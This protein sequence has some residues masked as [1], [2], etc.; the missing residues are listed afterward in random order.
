MFEVNLVP[1]LKHDAI[2]ALRVRNIILFVCIMASAISLV[3]VFILLSIKGGQ[4]LTMS[5]QDN[6]IDELSAKLNAFSDLDEMLTIQ[7]QMSNLDALAQN[8]Y[9]ISRIF[10]LL[11]VMQDRGADEVTFSGIDYNSENNLLMLEGQV[12]ARTEPYIDYRVLEEFI[13]NTE[14]ITYDYGNYVDST[15]TTIPAYC[16]TDTNAAGDHYYSGY[17]Q[18][19]YAWWNFTE[20]GCNPS[21]LENSEILSYAINP[22]TGASMAPASEE[23][24]EQDSEEDQDE[25][26][27]T[28]QGN[29]NN[30]NVN[31]NNTAN[32]NSSVQAGTTQTQIAIFRTPLFDEW[33][34]SGNMSADGNISGVPHFESACT[35]YT[36]KDD[37]EGNLTWTTNNEC[38]AVPNGV[39]VTDSSNGTNDSDELVL[40]FD[41]QVPIDQNMF[42]SANQFMMWMSPTGGNV[43]DSFVQ[44]ADMFAR[45]AADCAEGDETC[46]NIT[47][48]GGTTNTEEVD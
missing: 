39:T 38:L 8:K 25:Q 33:V 15:G 11:V 14:M 47:N 44:I 4:D 32:N 20:E 30:T 12:N 48:S 18:A 5:S 28:T 27:A 7:N 6:R 2:R 45:R 21:G 10:G 40:R 29:A 22:D 13:K 16:I 19:Y 46:N 3:I 36:S 23:N 43:T 41:A 26:N 31:N 34:S 35:A 1:E 17:Y 9:S 24:T 37:G 42:L